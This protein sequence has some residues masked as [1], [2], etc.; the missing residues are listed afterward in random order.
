MIINNF[1]NDLI[2]KMDLKGVINKMRFGGTIG[3]LR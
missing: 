1:R 3:A 2:E